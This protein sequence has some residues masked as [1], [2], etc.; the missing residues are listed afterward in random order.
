MDRLRRFPA[1]GVIRI[2]GEDPAFTLLLQ[3][4]SFKTKF[5]CYNFLDKACNPRYTVYRPAVKN[6]SPE[7]I[8]SAKGQQPVSRTV[9][10]SGMLF[11][12]YTQATKG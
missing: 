11:D 4:V 3:H 12:W 1:G 8:E 10:F 9:A 6:C 5:A 2:Q 7:F